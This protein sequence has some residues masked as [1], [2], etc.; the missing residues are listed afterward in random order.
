MLCF[1]CLL[2]SLAN[3]RSIIDLTESTFAWPNI[4]YIFALGDSY[5]TQGAN[6][7]TLGVNANTRLDDLVC[8]KFASCADITKLLLFC[9]DCKQRFELGG[10]L[11]DDVQFKLHSDI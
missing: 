11:G 6:S 3:A 10:I 1:T 2:E 5:T 4:E 8:S 9:T 7:S